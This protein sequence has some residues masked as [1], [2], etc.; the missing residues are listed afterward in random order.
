MTHSLGCASCQRNRSCEARLEAA[1]GSCPVNGGVRIGVQRIWVI[2]KRRKPDMRGA[3]AKIVTASALF[4]CFFAVPTYAQDTNAY[5]PLPSTRLESFA[6]NT[7]TV[8]IRGSAD[9]GVV[10]ADTG[11]IT[12]KC[13]E[14]SDASS[15]RKEVGISVDLIHNPSKE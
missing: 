6:T 14:V 12:L 3:R 11:S 2:I 5:A 15:G 8:I 4:L 13:R 7:G 1:L 10:L 9:V